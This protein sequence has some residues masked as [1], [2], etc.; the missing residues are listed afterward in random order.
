MD[1]V[2]FSYYYVAVSYTEM[3]VDFANASM[4]IMYLSYVRDDIY[5]GT[6]K[7]AGLENVLVYNRCRIIRI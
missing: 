2:S 4:Y 5:A 7:C 3:L 6:G 1:V